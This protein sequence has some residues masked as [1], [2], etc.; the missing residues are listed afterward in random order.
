MSNTEYSLVA[1]TAKQFL[2]V[3]GTL[4]RG[5]C[6]H[7]LLSDQE[8]LGV[9]QTIPKYRLYDLGDYPGLIEIENSGMA[10]EGE[11]W[12]V[13]EDCLT[14][15]DREEGVGEGLYQRRPVQLQSW[16]GFTEPE[17]Y[18]YLQSVS[19]ARE[20]GSSWVAR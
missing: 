13:T 16:T 12:R 18:F 20:M 8:F 7:H 4:K 15:L 9:A 2:F 11:V 3:Y 19:E 6:R 5:D 1:P 14:I 17:S 10:I